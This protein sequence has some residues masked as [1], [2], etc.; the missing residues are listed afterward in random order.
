LGFDGYNLA[1][2][3]FLKLS[4]FALGVLC[5]PT[6]TESIKNRVRFSGLADNIGVAAVIC[7]TKSNGEMYVE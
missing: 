1:D 5:T 4:N 2:S 3:F 7:K 6:G